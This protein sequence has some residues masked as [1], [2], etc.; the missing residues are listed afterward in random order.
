MHQ[1]AATFFAQAKGTAGAD[2]S[3]FVKDEFDA[4]LEC[5]ILAKGFPPLHLGDRGHD[6][7]KSRSS[8]LPLGTGNSAAVAVERLKKTKPESI[9]LVCLL[10]TSEGLQNCEV[11]YPNVPFCTAAIDGELNDHGYIV[12]GLGDA[13]DCLLGTK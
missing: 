5:G 3:Q 4:F 11:N 12:P 8:D 6:K 7:L 2:L 1:H 13:G 10:A 9:R